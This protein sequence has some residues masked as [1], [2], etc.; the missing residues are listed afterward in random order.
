MIFEQVKEKMG[1]AIV[2]L[3]YAELFTTDNNIKREI[4]SIS[5]KVKMISTNPHKEISSKEVEEVCSSIDSIVKDTDN[6]SVQTNLS[7]AK[8][9]LQKVVEV[10]ENINQ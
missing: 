1:D 6:T 2:N 4:V 9:D 5:N 10:L 8:E 7:E 3:N